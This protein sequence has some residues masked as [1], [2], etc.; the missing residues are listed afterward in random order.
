MEIKGLDKLMDQQSYSLLKEKVK[1]GNIAKLV[2]HGNEIHVICKE[3]YL[4]TL[5]SHFGSEQF[6]PY[7]YAKIDRALPQLVTIDYWITCMTKEETIAYRKVRD[8]EREQKKRA[9]FEEQVDREVQRRIRLE[10]EK[11][12]KERSVA[13]TAYF[14]ELAKYYEYKKRLLSV[15][16]IYQGIFN[17]LMGVD[18]KRENEKRLQEDIQRQIDRD[19]MRDP[20]DET[21]L[22]LR[23]LNQEGRLI[24][25]LET[26]E[27]PRRPGL[28]V[29]EIEREAR[30]EAER[31]AREES[32]R[33][34]KESEE[35]R[36]KE[37]AERKARMAAERK[38]RLMAERQAAE[39]ERRA[40]AEAERKARV[41]AERKAKLEAE[42]RAREQGARRETEREAREEAERR[43]RHPKADDG[44]GFFKAR[45][46]WR[47]WE[48]TYD[49]ERKYLSDTRSS[50][51]NQI[52]Q[53]KHK[54]SFKA[55]REWGL[56]G[57]DLYADNLIAEMTA[58]QIPK[59]ESAYEKPYYARFDYETSEAEPMTHYI[60]KEGVTD[61][62]SSEVRVISWMSPM[63]SLYYQKQL[64]PVDSPDGPITV[65][66]FRQFDL[67]LGLN[68]HDQEWNEAF[69]EYYD[70]ILQKKLAAN[71]NDKMKDIVETIQAEQD[72]IIRLSKNKPIIVQGSAG[73]GKTTVA[74]HR[75]AYLLYAHRNLDPSRFIVFGPNRIFLNYIEKVLP[76]LG[77]DG[78]EQTTF[79]E[80]AVDLL[81][82]GNLSIA[83]PVETMQIIEKSEPLIANRYL[84][85]S[86]IKGSL[87]FKKALSRYLEDYEQTCI[88]H[89]EVRIAIAED[90]E[91]AVT[92]EEL[93]RWFAVDYKHLPIAKRREF[94]LNR[95]E[96]A[97]S[98][99]ARRTE[100]ASLNPIRN[101]LL[102]I[103]RRWKE[104]KA[105]EIYSGFVS[106]EAHF[107]YFA[108]LLD[109]ESFRFLCRHHRLMREN[110]EIEYEDLTPLLYIEQFISG[111]VGARRLQDKEEKFVSY[112][113]AVID[114][115]QD[116]S[117]FQIDLIQS[118]VAPGSVMILGDLGQSIFSFRGIHKWD[119]LSAALGD[120]SY[121]ELRKSYRSTVEITTF[122]NR[123]IDKWS[124]GKFALSQPIVRHGSEPEIHI[125]NDSAWLPKIRSVLQG[126]IDRGNANIALITKTVKE[127]VELKKALGR[128]D[129]QLLLDSSDEYEGGIVISP[130]Y[131][132]KGIE[133]DAAVVVDASSEKYG[134]GSSDRKLLYVACTRA[135]H[136]LTVIGNGD[137]SPII[138]PMT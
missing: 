65:R 138:G 9:R 13:H 123:L 90:V 7:P 20:N 99:L 68:Y 41:Q 11:R 18:A 85:K 101:R 28:R 39:A 91:Y 32:E 4:G 6:V 10:E 126:M 80:W 108:D 38:E 5:P 48:R 92:S 84:L 46:E 64:G 107:S 137:L 40:E 24:R 8:E 124:E 86:Q 89:E 15:T 111:E 30:A 14:R 114:E 26:G 88:P 93:R 37:Q 62:E 133:F 75:L 17:F 87:F 110:K 73:S 130:V 134:D 34:T 125:A 72:S 35:R 74:L 69:Y 27:L 1:K 60:G 19:F 61:E 97:A 94:I 79:Q 109:L 120:F 117:P 127:A 58:K 122:A 128:K 47:G 29:E 22:L 63:S 44:F 129:T 96:R 102:G 43:E 55:R 104:P 83:E 112:Q 45:P 21:V 98:D 106:N 70:P 95:M 59:L 49:F 103:K 100:S 16:P 53:V 42:L 136:E 23:R 105:L 3:L 135:L 25:L 31:Q 77:V 132:S 118:V 131:L 121:M 57:G 113:Y 36:A 76:D 71:S 54:L 67:D 12:N 51:Q 52:R 50:I 66:L 56:G 81:D 115:G 119:E 116:Y 82:I 78:I 2:R 33:R